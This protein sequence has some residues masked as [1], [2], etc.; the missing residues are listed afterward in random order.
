MLCQGSEP[1]DGSRFKGTNSRS[2]LTGEGGSELEVLGSV[3][4]EPVKKSLW[5]FPTEGA[6]WARRG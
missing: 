5:A 1:S 6:V 2:S 4:G 3:L